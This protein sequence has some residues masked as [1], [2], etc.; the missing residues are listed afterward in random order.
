MWVVIES[1]Q[2]LL[3]WVGSLCF[4]LTVKDVISQSSALDVCCHASL[5]LWTAPLEHKPE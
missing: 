5:P 1:S 3:T 2:S 4:I